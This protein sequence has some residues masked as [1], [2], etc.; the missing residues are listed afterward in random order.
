MLTTTIA[1]N[2]S[3]NFPS[4]PIKNINKTSITLNNVKQGNQLLIKDNHGIVIYKE[5]I[6]TAGT[7]SKGFDLTALPDGHYF[8]ELEKD[9][10]IKFIPF[11][12]DSKK[13]ILNNEETTVYKPFITCKNNYIYLTQL[14]LNNDALDVKIYNGNE[15]LLYS[16]Q[17]KNTKTIEKAYKLSKKG[18]YKMVL[19]SNGRTYYEYIKF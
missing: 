8:F 12:V 1:S 10:E 3:E 14:A 9:I 18:N 5:K 6:K 7:Y 17:I 15:E 11:K 4:D 19:T 2:A 13:V 16:E